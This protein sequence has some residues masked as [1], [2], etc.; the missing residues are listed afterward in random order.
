M[1]NSGQVVHTYAFLF[2]M[3]YNLVLIRRKCWHWKFLSVSVEVQWPGMWSPCFF[4]WL[5]LWL[6]G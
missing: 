6:Q 3:Q 1:N 5:R 2:S 4:V